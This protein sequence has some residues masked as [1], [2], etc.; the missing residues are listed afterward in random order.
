MDWALLPHCICLHPCILAETLVS[1]GAA[2]AY[3]YVGLSECVRGTLAA[4]H[5]TSLFWQLLLAHGHNLAGSPL[6]LFGLSLG[7]NSRSSVACCPSLS[8][9][10]ALLVRR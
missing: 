10:E 1:I 7:D 3:C 2:E 9:A 8:S 6:V 5:L 4:T